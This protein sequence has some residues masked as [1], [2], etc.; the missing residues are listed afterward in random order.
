MIYKDFEKEVQ[1]IMRSQ[2]YCTIHTSPDFQCDQTGG[3]PTS[4]CVSWERNKAWLTLNESLPTEGYDM[5]MYRQMCADFGIRNCYYA[6]DFN[7]LLR[8][9][10]SDAIESAELIPDDETEGFSYDL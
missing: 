7:R 4:L 6:E 8:E 5:A 9:L 1:A 10:G 2:P 3:Y